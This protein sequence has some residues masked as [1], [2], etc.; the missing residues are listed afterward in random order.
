MEGEGK[1]NLSGSPLEF[2]A[3]CLYTVKHTIVEYIVGQESGTPYEGYI[4]ATE[5]LAT[6]I[7]KVNHLWLCNRVN[8][9]VS[10]VL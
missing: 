3:T 10:D 7:A 2:L 4:A 6:G 9:L 5:S 1:W 8:L